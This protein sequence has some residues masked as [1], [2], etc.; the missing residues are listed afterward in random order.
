MFLTFV[1]FSYTEFFVYFYNYKSNGANKYI[2]VLLVLFFFA[3]R[4]MGS[5]NILIS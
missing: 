2:V 4:L 3:H 1:C 5:V